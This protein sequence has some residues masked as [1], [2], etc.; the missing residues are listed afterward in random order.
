MGGAVMALR[1]IPPPQ[2]LRTHRPRPADTLTPIQADEYYPD[3]EDLPQQSSWFA[4]NA[5]V[6]GV[7]MLCML[8]MWYV[9]TTYVLPFVF[10][11]L[12]H[13]DCGDARICQY[14]LNV[15]HGGT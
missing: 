9:G 6:I 3:T 2:T 7:G 10:D 14:D 4:Q 5:F 8:I 1:N 12:N 13:W 15:G 11:K